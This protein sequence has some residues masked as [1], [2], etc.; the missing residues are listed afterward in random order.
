MMTDKTHQGCDEK[1]PALKAGL[2]RMKKAAIAFSGGVDSAF[3]LA[4]AAASGLDRLVA[5]T[6][7]SAFVTREEILR[8]GQVAQDLGVEHQVLTADILK[9]AKVIENPPE[10]C[11]HCKA[12]VFSLIKDAARRAKIAHVLHGV[13]TDDLKDFRPGMKAAGE[14]GFEAPLLDAGFSKQEIRICSK[15]MGLATWDLPSQS[16]LATR[17]PF[18]TVITEQALHRIGQAEIFIKSLGFAHV[19]VRCHGRLARIETDD[20]SMVSMMQLRQ[21]ISA[22]L[23]KFGFTFVSLDMDGYRTGK[24][25]PAK[26]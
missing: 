5:M 8:A 26:K 12:A 15:Q 17:I 24:M 4:V 22:G 6:V 20:R 23:K 3:L 18:G 21:Q 11:Y 9:D 25:N 13:N 16:C 1:V 7:D 14:L 2:Q 10:R 19:R